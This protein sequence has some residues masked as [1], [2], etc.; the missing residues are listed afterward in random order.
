[1]HRSAIAA[2]NMGDSTVDVKHLERVLPQ[3]L[4]DFQ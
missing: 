4:L 3:Y 1:V 2:R